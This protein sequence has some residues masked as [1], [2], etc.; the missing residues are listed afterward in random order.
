[1][2]NRNVDGYTTTPKSP[3]NTH[4]KRKKTVTHWKPNEY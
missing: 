4:E 1:M 3:E 2:M